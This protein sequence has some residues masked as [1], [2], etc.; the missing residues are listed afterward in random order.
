MITRG[1]QEG[2]SFLKRGIRMYGSMIR[3]ELVRTLSRWQPWV[4]LLLWVGLLIQ[5]YEVFY[6]E[7][8]MYVEPGSFNVFVAFTK[9]HGYDLAFLTPVIPLLAV[10]VAGDSLAWD[11]RTGFQH[12]MLL[13]MNG[14]EYILGKLIAISCITFLFVWIGE[15]LGFLYAMIRY[16]VI[17]PP[18]IIEGITPDYAQGLF[19][20]Y[21]ILFLLLII[22]NTAMAAVAFALIAVALSTKIKNLYAIL[23][24]PW[25]GF[26]SLEFIT[27]ILGGTR[28]S[29]L[30]YTGYYFLAVF[31]YKVWE[32]PL[33][34]VSL[35]ALAFLLTYVLF[36][37]QLKRGGQLVK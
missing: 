9:T 32:I 36:N 8:Q 15:L 31:Q 26:T 17:F 4:A 23:A 7:P 35:A 13:R 27:Q 14:K 25:L 29:P 6:P 33:F 34:W 19:M 12:S 2:S 28:I 30:K 18:Y 5:G 37:T 20:D 22:F 16:P 11:V 24:L 10:M 21:P 3:M 1:A